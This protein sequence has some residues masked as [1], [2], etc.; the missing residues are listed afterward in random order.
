MPWRTT[1][2][3]PDSDRRAPPQGANALRRTRHLPAA[4]MQRY[5]KPSPTLLTWSRID[6]WRHHLLRAAS[7]S[8]SISRRWLSGDP[9]GCSRPESIVLPRSLLLAWAGPARSKEGEDVGKPFLF[10]KNK[11]SQTLPKEKPSRHP[12]VRTLAARQLGRVAP[13]PTPSSLGCSVAAAS[14]GNRSAVVELIDTR[15]PRYPLTVAFPP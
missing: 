10:R 4:V 13:L 3:P 15:S 8:P 9:H 5:V 6:S 2:P 1:R 14:R 11:V 7:P 12:G